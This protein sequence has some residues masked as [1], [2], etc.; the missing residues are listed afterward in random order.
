MQTSKKIP[1]IVLYWR[2]IPVVNRLTWI[3]LLGVT[4]W[5]ITN[6]KGQ[7]KITGLINIDLIY[8][9]HSLKLSWPSHVMAFYLLC[10]LRVQQVGLWPACVSFLGEHCCSGIKS[11]WA[12]THEWL[13]QA[14]FLVVV[15]TS[16][17]AKQCAFM[18]SY[19]TVM[20]CNNTTLV[21]QTMP[22]HVI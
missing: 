5:L 21:E 9:N 10:W 22:C 6:I 20:H 18:P 7:C 12:L 8:T 3:Y 13:C 11:S 4:C 17:R 15:S 1:R 16:L 19:D 2:K 14:E